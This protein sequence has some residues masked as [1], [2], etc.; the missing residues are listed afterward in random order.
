MADDTNILP[1]DQNYIRAVG[2]ESDTTPGLVLAG[3]IDEATGRILVDNAGGGAGTG[4]VTSV[5]VV[6]ANGVSGS[7]ATAT[8]TPAI[9]LTLGAITPTSVNGITLSGSG[10]LANSGT[11]SLTGFTGSGSSSGTN[12]GDQTTITGN[13]GTATALQNARTIGGVS[14]NGTANITVATATGGFT[15]S[16]GNLALGANSL[17]LTGSIASTGSRVTKGWFTDV[18]STNMVTIGGT[19]LTTVAQTLQ[20]KT[21]TNSNNVLGGV[22]MTLGSD[23]DGDT[24]YRASNVLTRLAKGTAGQVYKMNSGATAPSWQNNV[25]N[26]WVAVASGASIT[27]TT[28]TQYLVD[29]GAYTTQTLTLPTSSAVG[30]ILVIHCIY[31]NGLGSTT[32]IAQ[33]SG[34]AIEFLLTNSFT[35]T[36]VGTSG[37]IDRSVGL[38]TLILVCT[39]ANTTWQVLSGYGFGGASWLDQSDN[40]LTA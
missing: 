3:Q 13:A 27:M 2:F 32:K 28:N 29:G 7:V 19:S 15:V 36:T 5:S 18:E 22:T 9:T 21:I 40:A 23:A 35:S 1:K 17:T 30:D 34:Q 10:S 20:N 38:G 24:Y 25:N 11:S 14:F 4:T 26:V 33:A 39:V 31:S 12:T 8:T 16:G 37:Y 6:T